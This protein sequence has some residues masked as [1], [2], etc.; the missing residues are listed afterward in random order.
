MVSTKALAAIAL[1]LII[2]MPIGI[3]F[4]TAV[5]QEE[6]DSWQTT[7]SSK[8]SDLMLNHQT[9][10]YGSYKGT[11]NNSALHYQG[12]YTQTIE[13]PEYTTVTSTYS[14]LPIYNETVNSFT[15]PRYEYTNTSGNNTTFTLPS[16]TYGGT[17]DAYKVTGGVYK[18]QY[19]KNSQDYTIYCPGINADNV[20]VFDTGTIYMI[21][22]SASTWELWSANLTGG[23]AIITGE[24]VLINSGISSITVTKTS[25]VTHIWWYDYVEIDAN[26]PYTVSLGSKWESIHIGNNYYSAANNATIGGLD[27]VVTNSSI[28]LNGE[29]V[30]TTEPIY[31]VANVATINANETTP[32]GTFADPADGWTLPTINTTYTWLNNQVNNS[33][34]FYVSLPLGHALTVDNELVL[35]RTA[36]GTTASYGTTTNIGDYSMLQI[37]I[38]NDSYEITGISGWPSMGTVPSTFNTITIEKSTPVANFEGIALSVTS[39]NIHLRVDNANVIMGTYPTTYDYA[40]N[41]QQIYPDTN[42]DIYLNSIGI[43]GDYINFGG[44]QLTVDNGSV[45]INGKTYRLLHAHLSA[46]N[47]GT[48]YSLRI[49]GDEVATTSEPPT[50]FWGGEWSVTATAYKI[51]QVHESVTVWHA[52][53]FGLDKTGFAVAGLLACGALLVVLGLSGQRS[54][55]KMGVLLLICGGAAIVFLLII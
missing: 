2:A 11:S 27:L 7:S 40:L 1:T 12:E 24:P 52:G 22:D 30:G 42:I 25:I 31:A 16:A 53:E 6:T 41:L 28:R 37:V 46:W 47:E 20:T 39:K 8:I 14:S 29:L 26:T 17:H 48:H 21:R 38:T 43:Y 36:F 10:Y 35:M 15:V 50:I 32:S 33:V 19:T 23:E 18:V 44:A 55:G 5:H 45:S 13:A 4:L 54:G 51:E 49:N 34:T 3:G 9:P